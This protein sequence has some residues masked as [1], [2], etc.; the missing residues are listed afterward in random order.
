[1]SAAEANIDHSTADYAD[2]TDSAKTIS[3]FISQRPPLYLR[4][5]RNP[6]LILAAAIGLRPTFCL[7]KAAAAV[8]I[9]P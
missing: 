3:I 4:H 2:Q 7:S 6:R 8:E 9:V 1:V 5:P